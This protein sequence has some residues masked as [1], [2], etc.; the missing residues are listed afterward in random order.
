MS[1]YMNGCS[2]ERCRTRGF[3]GPA[4][5]VT[6]GVLLLLG[7]FTR[8]DFGDTWPI[9]LIVI[10]VVKVVQSNASTEGHVG[11]YVA[12]PP[13]P[14]APSVPPVVPPPPSSDQ[15]QVSHG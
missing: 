12:Y 5:L 7:Q 4:I 1:H 10:G 13:Y 9:L 11:G 2:C 14:V 6:L 3:L 15:G 8:W